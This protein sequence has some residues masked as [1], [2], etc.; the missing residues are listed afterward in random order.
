M[1][2]STHIVAAGGETPA[3]RPAWCDGMPF[4]VRTLSGIGIA[5]LIT[6]LVAS[7]IITFLVL[8]LNSDAP[9][10][11]RRTLLVVSSIYALAAMAVGTTFGGLLHA[12]TLRWLTHGD[13]PTRQ[14]AR[15]S[16][17]TPRSTSR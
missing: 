6:N 1:S 10:G 7:V 8:T 5:V 16:L 17:R 2:Q 14:E 15:R 13:A 11:D 3:A 4:V 12:R 9:D